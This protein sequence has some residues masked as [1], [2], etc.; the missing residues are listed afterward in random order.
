MHPFIHISLQPCINASRRSHAHTITRFNTFIHTSS[1]HSYTHM[2]TNIHRLICTH[3]HI[4]SYIP[5]L[6]RLHF[7]IF[8]H[9]YIHTHSCIHTFMLLCIHT[10]LHSYIHTFIHLHFVHLYTSLHWYTHK[11]THSYLHCFTRFNSAF[12]ENTFS[13]SVGLY[14]LDFKK[15]PKKCFLENTFQKSTFTFRSVYYQCYLG[16]L[17][18]YLFAFWVKIGCLVK[19]LHELIK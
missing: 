17:W 2:H 19:Y 4:D 15:V 10:Y 9:P 8:I 1:L 7:Y 3:K 16:T 12:L 5:T 11:N 18:F 13:K 6:V 14:I